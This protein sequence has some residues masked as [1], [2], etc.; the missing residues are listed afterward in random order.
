MASARLGLIPST[1]QIHAIAMLTWSP[2]KAAYTV[3]AAV[4]CRV[5]SYEKSAR[6]KAAGTVVAPPVDPMPAAAVVFLNFEF[7]TDQAAAV[8]PHQGIRS[9]AHKAHKRATDKML[10]M[11]EVFPCRSVAHQID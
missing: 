3:P 9:S 4:G 11:L 10:L 2:P 6:L 7:G 5:N 1:I 8:A